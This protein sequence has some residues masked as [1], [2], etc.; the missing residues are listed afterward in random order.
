MGKL[1]LCTSALAKNP[2]V[3]TLTKTKVYSIEEISYYLYNNIYSVYEDILDDTLINWVKDELRMEEL[4]KK[5]GEL[6]KNRNNMRDIVVTILC[7]NDYYSE[8]EITA[9]IAI[10]DD[11]MNLPAIRRQKIKADN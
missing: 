10:I 1:I 9:I 8:K 2:Y 3:F 4:S 6:K 5:L 7:S 11:I